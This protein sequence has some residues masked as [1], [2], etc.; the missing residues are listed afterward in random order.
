MRRFALPSMTKTPRPRETVIQNQIMS[1]LELRGWVVERMNSGGVPAS[2]GGRK[3]WVNMHTKGTPDVQAMRKA[4]N[5][6]TEVLYVEVK[7]PGEEA[8][9]HQLER[10]TFLRERTGATVI[11]A[12][13]WEEVEEQLKEDHET[14][15]NSRGVREGVVRAGR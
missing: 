12:T 8:E 3:Y 15:S 4:P 14:H 10:H 7:R 13:S 1:Y 5:G 9:D 2:Y 11:V 6:Y